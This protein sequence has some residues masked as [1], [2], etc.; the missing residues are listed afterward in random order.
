MHVGFIGFGLIAGSIARA[1]RANP[2]ASTWTMAAWS[3]TG[4]GPHR[5]VS[6]GVVDVAATRPD[7]VLDDADLVVLAAPATACLTLIDELAGPWRSRLPADAVVTDVASTKGAIVAR[8]DAAGLRFVGGHPMAGREA[9]GY[10]VSDG[11]LF[12]DRPWVVVPG[13]LAGPDDVARVVELVRACGARVVRMDAAAHDAAVAGISH[14]PLLVAA[15]L[16]EAIAAGSGDDWPIAT[17]LAAGG[18]RDMTRVARG[19]PAMG[20]AIAV[21]NAPAIA[22]RLRDLQAVL[23]GWLAELEEPG[24]PDETAVAARLAA[25]RDLLGGPR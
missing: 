11:S 8:A 1:V 22:G 4:D 16:V 3:P 24:G 23:D 12:V 2:A 21:T 18:W 10:A 17:S 7:D 25:A 15:A 5:A 19:D 20:A 9:T 13:S 14:L 6:E